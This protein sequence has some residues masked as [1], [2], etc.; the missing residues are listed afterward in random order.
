MRPDIT[1]DASQLDMFDRKILDVLSRDGRIPVTELSK[2]VGLSKSPCQVRMKRL[3]ADGF[4]Q[5][6]HARLDPRKMGLEH[7]AFVEVKMSDTREAALAEF[8][9]AVRVLSEVE[10]CHLIAGAFDYLLKV[11]TRD[12]HSYREVLG[13]KI[14]SLP[15]VASTSTHV[16]MESIKDEAF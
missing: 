15:H 2:E 6:F 5:G 13:E 9:R 8:R 12:I 16:S 14:S 4:I 7:I 10:Q 11:R 3:Q 1:A